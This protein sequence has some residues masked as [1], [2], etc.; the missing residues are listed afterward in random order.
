[1]SLAFS[2]TTSWKFPTSSSERPPIATERNSKGGKKM[3]DR[4]FKLKWHLITARKNA[5]TKRAKKK[6]KNTLALAW[7]MVYVIDVLVVQS[8]MQSVL[9]QKARRAF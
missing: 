4:V 7:K 8:A 5:A 3:Q 9:K 6:E 1:M 2:V